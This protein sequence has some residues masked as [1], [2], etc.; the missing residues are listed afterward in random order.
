M[1]FTLGASKRDVEGV[2]AME[3]VTT[4]PSSLSCSS[5]SSPDEYP[6]RLTN[7]ILVD[8]FLL[9]KFLLCEAMD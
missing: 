1:M 5:Y 2:D 6:S 8:I 3:M 7:N 9:R 4:P